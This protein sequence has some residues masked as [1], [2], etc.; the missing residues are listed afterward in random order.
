M[1]TRA[2]EQDDVHV[3][4]REDDVPDE[5]AR[6]IGRLSRGPPMRVAYSV[7]P[8]D[9]AIYGPKLEFALQDR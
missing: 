7:Q 4:C 6:F 2:V 9:G 3:F 5:V 8:G 1:R